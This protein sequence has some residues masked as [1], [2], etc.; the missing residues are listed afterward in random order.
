MKPLTFS[1]LSAKDH[2]G[3]LHKATSPQWLASQGLTIQIRD[4]YIS[5][6]KQ[7][8]LRGIHA[9]TGTAC[10]RKIVHCV[11]GAILDVI[12]DLRKESPSYG[13]YC[14]IEISCND[15]LGIVVP[16]RCAHGFL[17]LQD[18]T[19]VSCAT[20]H[21]YAPESELCIRW[22]S[23]DFDWPVSDPILSDKDAHGTPLESL[24]SEDAT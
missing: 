6:S 12:I 2:R 11:E 9:Q 5:I 4:H 19:I 7:H 21:P 8:V 24:L 20:E 3:A 17:S 23:I 16:E 14:T 13:T 15:N 1:T 10:G 22:D 18:Q